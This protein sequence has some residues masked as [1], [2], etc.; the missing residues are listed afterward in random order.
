LGVFIAKTM[1]EKSGGSL[2]F[3]NTVNGTGAVVTAEWPRK[4]VEAAAIIR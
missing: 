3:A 2:R 1:I 4:R